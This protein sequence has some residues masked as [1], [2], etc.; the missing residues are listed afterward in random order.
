[1]KVKELE[2]GMLLETIDDS[3]FF[4]GVEQ[5]VAGEKSLFPWVTIRTKNNYW[6]KLKDVG[7]LVMYLGT[8]KDVN[9]TKDDISWSARYVMMNEKIYAVDPAAWRKMRPVE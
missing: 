2:V 8:R 1:M 6:N 4:L 3:S 5:R 9:I 7:H